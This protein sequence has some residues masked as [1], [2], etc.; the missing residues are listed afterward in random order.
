RRDQA[1]VGPS[2]TPLRRGEAPRGLALVGPDVPGRIP[3]S[4]P[5]VPGRD[6]GAGTKLGRGAGTV[7]GGKPRIRLY[8]SVMKAAHPVFAPQGARIGKAYLDAG[9]P[10][11]SGEPDPEPACGRH[12]S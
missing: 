4:G 8:R 12:W 2:G 10:P 7:S 3:C 6:A 5:A 11:Q 1:V 9:D